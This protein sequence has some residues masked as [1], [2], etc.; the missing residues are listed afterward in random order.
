MIFVGDRAIGW[1]A[2]G[3]FS[4]TEFLRR[5]AK[6]AI[7]VVCS[8]HCTSKL[9]PSCGSELQHPKKPTG[10][11]FNGTSFCSSPKCA[12]LGRLQNRDILAA[13]SIVARTLCGFLIGGSLGS[14]SKPVKGIPKD[15]TRISL[16]GALVGPPRLV[17][18]AAG[19]PWYVKFDG[20][21]CVRNTL[22]TRA[23]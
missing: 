11:I 7:V 3:V 13:A 1:Q 9:C 16:F 18:A 2:S 4:H 17:A 5:L 12:S 14:Y 22:L 8:E 21:F 10:Y 23:P 6:V 15:D 19:P 20:L